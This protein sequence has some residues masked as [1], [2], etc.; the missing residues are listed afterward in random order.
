MESGDIKLISEVVV[1]D[2]VL[3]ADSA[4]SL[5]YSTVVYLPHQKNDVS[6]NFVQVTTE[7]GR[8]V[9]MTVTEAR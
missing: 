8:T 7:F 4:G 9:N 1:G 3:A 2:R 6:T 5:L